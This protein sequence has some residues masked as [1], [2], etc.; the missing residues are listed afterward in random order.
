MAQVLKN[1]LDY[2]NV[3]VVHG[4]DD[5]NKNLAMAF[6]EAA[7]DPTL[8]I[9]VVKTIETTVKPTEKQAADAINILKDATCRVVFFSLHPSSAVPVMRQASA[10]GIMGPESGWL[11]VVPDA[12]TVG[13]EDIKTDMQVEVSYCD[14]GGEVDDCDADFVITTEG[15]PADLLVG[16]MGFLPLSPSGDARDTFLASYNAL[17]NTVGR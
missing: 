8:D 12:I 6:A 3:C 10:A 14:A 9:T 17:P 1:D 7:L 13:V 11:W 5:Y 15:A 16:M 4:D 2:D